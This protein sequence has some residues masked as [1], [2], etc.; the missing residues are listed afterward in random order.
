MLYIVIMRI[1]DE[2]NIEGI[3]HGAIL[4]V[5][6]SAWFYFFV[7]GLF[8]STYIDY[9]HSTIELMYV[10]FASF[11]AYSAIKI[12]SAVTLTGLLFLLLTCVPLIFL[13]CINFV[14]DKLGLRKVL[15]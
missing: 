13:L 9:M 12:V 14:W 11:T 8:E 7:N 3:A 15:D 6:V 4:F 1:L 5:S 2:L 10:P